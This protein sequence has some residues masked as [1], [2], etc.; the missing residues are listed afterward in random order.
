MLYFAICVY[1]SYYVVY[2]V[3]FSSG[4]PGIVNINQLNG[5]TVYPIKDTQNIIIW[6]STFHESNGTWFFRLE[7]N[8]GR[9]DGKERCIEWYKGEKDHRKFTEHLEPCP[10]TYRQALWDERFGMD[11]E[12]RHRI[13]AYTVFESVHRWGQECCYE[14]SSGALIKGYPDGGTARKNYLRGKRTMKE[15]G[16]IYCCTYSNMCHL[17]YKRR[18]T[19]NCDG[20]K[21]TEWSKYYLTK[22]LFLADLL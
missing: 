9:I 14:R 3:C 12:E 7:E 20:Y 16:Y 6:A 19:N 17:Y 13:C 15:N 8:T 4:T 1:E 10:C 18:P 11:P 2:L 22:L 5:S 21:P